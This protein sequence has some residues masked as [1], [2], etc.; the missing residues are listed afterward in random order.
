MEG[1]IMAETYAERYVD[2]IITADY[3]L[4]SANTTPNLRLMGKYHVLFN[5][6]EAGQNV[7]KQ[8]DKCPYRD[9][10][11]FYGRITNYVVLCVGIL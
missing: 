10:K 5:S 11:E 4:G 6:L 1:T 2:P 3:F 8:C 9:L 7:I